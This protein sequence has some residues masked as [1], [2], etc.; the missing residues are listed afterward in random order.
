MPVNT[1]PQKTQA[2]SKWYPPKKPVM[3]PAIQRDR[4][5]GNLAANLAM[6]RL[7]AEYET[8]AAVLSDP[9]K[10]SCDMGVAIATEWAGLT[11]EHFSSPDL[12]LIF[13]AAVAGR[14]LPLGRVLILARRLLMTFHH[15]DPFAPAFCKGPRWS[16]ESL[17]SLC[18]QYPGATILVT[19]APALI[20]LHRRQTKAA[21]H[22]QY[23]RHLLELE[24]A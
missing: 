18:D 23:V 9:T 19:L 3:L 20:E 1:L 10:D 14:H 2:N 12:S 8:L 22:F 4:D 21:K 16:N 17:A 11:A 6:K 7:N 5:L 24:V 13:Q 15:W